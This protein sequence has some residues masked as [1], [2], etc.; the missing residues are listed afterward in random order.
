MLLAR[1]VLAEKRRLCSDFCSGN[2]GKNE[3][4]LQIKA[5]VSAV[6]RKKGQK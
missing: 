3:R 1:S 2:C 4:L 6:N 5:A